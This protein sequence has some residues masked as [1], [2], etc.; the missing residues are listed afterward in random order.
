MAVRRFLHE[1]L[2]GL[3]AAEQL[4]LAHQRALGRLACASAALAEPLIISAFI[5]DSEYELLLA[6][7]REQAENVERQLS[8]LPSEINEEDL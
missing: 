1:L 4:T 2:D 8:A 6:V 3:V 5:L 7:L